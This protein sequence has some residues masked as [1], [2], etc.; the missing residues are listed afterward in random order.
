[1][2]RKV[3]LA[4]LLLAAPAA[5]QD[6]APSMAPSPGAAEAAA[7]RPHRAVGI[8]TDLAVEAAQAANHYCATLPKNYRIT[9]LVTDAASVPIVLITQDNGAQITQRIAMG[10]SQLVAK[11][12]IKSIDAMD[13]AK[14]DKAFEAEVA[15]NPLIAVARRGGLPIMLD[16]QQV[17][18]ISVSGTDGHD[19]ECAQ[20]GLDKI[21]DRLKLIGG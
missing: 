14:T 6:V 16:G 17:G 18:T 10:K 21:K 15:A 8:T 11:Y 4:A 9:T 13:R 7:P 12:K 20:V 2:M 5:A 1:M 3:A 19:D